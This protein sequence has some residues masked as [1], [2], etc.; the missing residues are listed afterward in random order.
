MAQEQASPYSSS[1]SSAQPAG[2][3]ALQ[4]GG[5]TAANGTVRVG[6]RPSAIVSLSPTATEMLYAIGAGAC[7]MAFFGP[8]V[9]VAIDPLLVSQG[10]PHTLGRRGHERFLRLA[11]LRR[12]LRH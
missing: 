9:R 12:R 10:S 11:G 3:T 7:A 4:T 2:Q 6:K 1:I 8:A 5:S